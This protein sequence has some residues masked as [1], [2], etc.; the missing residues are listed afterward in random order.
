MTNSQR[1]QAKLFHSLHTNDPVLVLANSW[2]VASARIVEAAGASAIATTSA[3]VAWSLGCPDGDELDRDRAIELVGHIVAAVS[4][5]VTAD[6]ESGYATHA[7][8]VGDTVRGFLAAGAVGINLEDARYDGRAPLR[9]AADQAERI[10]AAR[11]AADEARVPL[12]INARTDTYLRSVG[13]PDKRLGET[14]ERA[15]TY[16]AAGASGIFVPGVA[17]PATIAALAEGISAPLNILV[18]PGSPTTGELGELGVARAS[19]GSSIATVAYGAVRRSAEELF[20][21]GSY[22]SLSGG[23]SYG[24]L[25][26]LLQRG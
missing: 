14:L 13:D 2:D 23:L 1:D 11:A 17:D 21:S 19:A 15:A 3:G 22:D 9:D 26:A 25:N 4:L 16:L 8:G 12:Y 7:E 5:P 6:I 18:G 24:E 20:T 10:A